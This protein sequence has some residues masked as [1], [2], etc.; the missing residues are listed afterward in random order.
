MSNKHAKNYLN[1]IKYLFPMF[2]KHEKRF[3]N[4]LTASIE[5]YLHDNPSASYDSICSE[6]GTPQDVIADYIE[7]LDIEYIIKRLKT[8]RIVRKILFTLLITL[9][10]ALVIYT[11]FAYQSY[12]D[13][14][15]AIPTKEI[16]VIE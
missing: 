15:S 9:I 3:L 5:N 13:A 1:Q 12:L 10:I 7:A 6:F 16:I 2:S 14:K 8:R 11:F 4:D